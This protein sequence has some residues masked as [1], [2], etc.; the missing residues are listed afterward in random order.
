MM[1]WDDINMSS[2]LPL[3]EQEEL[4]ADKVKNSRFPGDT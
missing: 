2:L 3:A 1:D 4:A